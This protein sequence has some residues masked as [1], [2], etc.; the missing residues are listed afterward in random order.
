MQCSYSLKGNTLST[1]SVLAD[2]SE[3]WQEVWLGSHLGISM[4]LD[5]FA[6][7]GAALERKGEGGPALFCKVSGALGSSF[8]QKPLP[9]NAAERRA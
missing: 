9:P 5:R 8:H 7:R 2:D 4:E 6:P 3:Y 1:A